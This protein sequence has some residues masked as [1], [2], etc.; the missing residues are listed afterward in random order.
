MDSLYKKCSK[1]IFFK[2]RRVRLKE[3]LWAVLWVYLLLRGVLWGRAMAAV[4]RSI[5]RTP[6]L[7]YGPIA[8]GRVAGA[9]H[10]SLL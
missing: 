10:A 8:G 3:V 5:D 4:Q 9:C 6:L 1:N 7:C 2:K